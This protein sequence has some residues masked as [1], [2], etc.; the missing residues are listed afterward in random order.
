[1]S[2]RTIR[3]KS[4]VTLP[5]LHVKENLLASNTVT[6]VPRVSS[7]PSSIRWTVGL[8]AFLA[9]VSVVLT[10][11]I[12]ADSPARIRGSLLV[13]GGAFGGLLYSL[14][15]N[16]RKFVLTSVSNT[17]KIDLGALSDILVGIGGAVALFGAAKSMGVARMESTT[18]PLQTVGVAIIA[19]L[20]GKTILTALSQR[21]AE[22]VAKEAKAT[23]E[24]A[25]AGADEA[26]TT[27]RTAE[28]KAKVAE[29][30]GRASSYFGN[31]DLLTEAL[32][33]FEE[34]K[35]LDPASPTAAIG[36]A[37]VKREL[38]RSKEQTAEGKTL[39]K[40]ATDLFGEAIQK[41]GIYE[42]AKAH[43]NRACC[44]CLLGEDIGKWIEDLRQ[45]VSL[46]PINKSL[47]K[48]ELDRGDFGSVKDKSDD[49]KLFKEVVGEGS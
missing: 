19:G 18:S 9:V 33:A 1:M 27:S 6:G 10:F 7:P 31:R 26:K 30:I 29:L 46:D 2:S 43:F 15:Q 3:D 24:E 8:A 49:L 45:A 28:L 5:Y 41:D 12:A 20:A 48:E 40:E 36:V 42:K 37:S 14:I 34:A 16:D 23:A 39:L 35:R 17:I 21:L 44:R 4:T 32:R 13:L 22:Q 11:L 38:A 25:K 47:A